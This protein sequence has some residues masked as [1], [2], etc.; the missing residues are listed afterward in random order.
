[1]IFRKW[2][3]TLLDLLLTSFED[4]RARNIP[5]FF[6]LIIADQKMKRDHFR[7]FFSSKLISVMLNGEFKMITTQVDY[8][9]FDP[10]LNTLLK[11]KTIIRRGKEVKTDLT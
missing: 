3:A 2:S 1:L 4:T 8:L 7:S 6:F 9:F 11:G 5:P 10:S